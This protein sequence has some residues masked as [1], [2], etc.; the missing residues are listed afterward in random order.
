MNA[1]QFSSI[2]DRPSDSIERPKPLPVGIYLFA[3]KGQYK[4]DVSSQKKTP[5]AEWQVVPLQAG[6]A[7]DQEALDECLT[8]KTTGEKKALADKALKATFYLTDD[9]IWRLTEFLTHC[10]IEDGPI[11]LRERMSQAAGAQFLGEVIHESGKNSS[12]FAKLGNTAP[13]EA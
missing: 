6:D 9:A 11:S 8:N 7:V 10:G 1:P 12:V 3:V 2:L 5:Y 4:E 13:V